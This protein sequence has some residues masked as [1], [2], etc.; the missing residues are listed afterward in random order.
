VGVVLANII[1]KNFPL[2]Y[3]QREEEEKKMQ[4]KICVQEQT[5]SVNADLNVGMYPF[6]SELFLSLLLI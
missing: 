3:K 1:E 5:K 2:E 4:L 6:E